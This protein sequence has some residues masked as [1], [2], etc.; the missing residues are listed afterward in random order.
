MWKEFTD[1]GNLKYP[2]LETVTQMKPFYAMRAFGGT[3]FFV[4]ALLMVYNLV[5]TVRKGK[6]VDDEA[7]APALEGS[8]AS[9]GSEHWHRPIERK[10]VPFLVLT[11]R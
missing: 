8:Y 11:L 1:A 9:H 10:P 3:L 5:A 4:G 6:V 2:F 7:E